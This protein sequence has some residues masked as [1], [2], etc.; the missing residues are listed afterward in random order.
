MWRRDIAML[1]G[2]K[3]KVIKPV[4][5]T[6]SFSTTNYL[7]NLPSKKSTDQSITANH[8]NQ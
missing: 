5:K 7:I 3:A 1:Q 4:S 6:I 8:Q 2:S